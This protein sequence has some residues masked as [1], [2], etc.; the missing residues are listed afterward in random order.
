MMLV[1]E[2]YLAKVNVADL[3]AHEALIAW[4]YS[5]LVNPQGEV[6]E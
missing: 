4:G 1:F 2:V 3:P 6:R 5:A